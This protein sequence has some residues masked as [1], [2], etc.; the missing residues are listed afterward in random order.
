MSALANEVVERLKSVLGEP[1]PGKPYGLHE[2]EIDE[3]E[4]KYLNDCLESTFVSSGGA[5]IP[6]FEQRVA[7]ITGAKYAV[8][9]S[10]GTVGL[11]VALYLAGVRPGDE[12][13]VPTL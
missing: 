13:I 2:P 12:V 4:K 3:L 10:N 5:F 6:Q 7:E 11:Q 1:Q 8:A 9:V